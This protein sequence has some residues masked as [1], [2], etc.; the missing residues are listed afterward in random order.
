MQYALRL[1]PY[2]KPAKL[3]LKREMLLCITW[4]S[5]KFAPSVPIDSLN[6][7]NNGSRLLRGK[8]SS[9]TC[10]GRD[11]ERRRGVVGRERGRL[12]EVG[13]GGVVDITVVVVVEK[14]EERIGGGGG[15]ASW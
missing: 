10:R 6:S 9:E 5:W 13:C 14:E 8:A 12:V 11:W 15:W 2:R 1:I 3:S 7:A 4:R